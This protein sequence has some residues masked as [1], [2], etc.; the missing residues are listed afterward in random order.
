MSDPPSDPARL[1][2]VLDD[3]ADAIVATDSAMRVIVWTR[4]AEELFGWSAADADGRT[5]HE[6]GLAPIEPEALQMTQHVLAGHA[7]EGTYAVVTKSGDTIYVRF[8]AT[9]LWQDGR[10]GGIGLLCRD[11]L[12]PTGQHERTAGRMALLADAGSVLGGS[13]DVWKTL[14]DIA[15]LFVPSFADHCIIDLYDERGDLRRLVSVSL[16]GFDDP[17]AWIASGQIV[18]YPAGHMC[19][20]AMQSLQPVMRHVTSDQLLDIAHDERIAAIY[21][22]V[23]VRSVI[24][25]PLP[26]SE[27]VLELTENR[28][29]ASG[30]V[31]LMRSARTDLYETEDV[32]LVAAVAQRA[33]LALDNAWLYNYQLRMVKTLQTNLLPTKPHTGHGVT[34]AGAYRPGALS[35]VGGDFYDVMELPSGRSGLVIGDVQ[36]RGAEAAVVMGQLR[37]SLRAYALQDLPPAQILSYLDQVVQDLGEELIVTCMFAV[38][39]PYLRTCTVANAG[40]PPPLIVRPGGR[41]KPVAEVEANVPLGV[42]SIGGEPFTETELQIEPGSS[43]LFYTD[44]VVERRELPWDAAIERAVIKVGRMP[45]ASADDLANALLEAIPGDA[46]DDAAVLVFQAAQEELP[47]AAYSLPRHPDA[48]R[49]ARRHTRETLLE[50]DLP[51]DADLAELLVSEL[52]TNALKHSAVGHHRPDTSRPR[53]LVGSLRGTKANGRIPFMLRRGARSLWIEVG[54]PDA[55]LPRRSD[56]GSDDE[57]GRGL[58]LV[59][60]LS[61]RWGARA[62]GDGKVVWVELRPRARS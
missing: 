4:R 37:A 24:A 41:P 8:R 3:L 31:T 46:G 18:E 48:V 1:R 45:Y 23:G 53:R 11:S 57:T 56:P 49:Q 15:E 55:R 44:G 7:W 43:L 51:E 26:R 58:V 52:V 34:V 42:A 39:D 5:L 2:R 62:T 25:M 14:A 27:Q 59:D 35:Q 29:P 19:A 10:V 22:R 6:L 12:G 32:D 17:D 47:Y 28:Q 20:E 30:V 60:S 54:D 36:G 33:G 61:T 38:F 16:P 9:P 13:L 50:W 40:H 21:R